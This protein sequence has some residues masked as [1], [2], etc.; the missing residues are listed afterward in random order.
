MTKD[1]AFRD[2]VMG[3]LLPVGPAR[4]R[5]MF[6]G[7][8]IFMDDVMFGLIADS[9]LYFKV[10]DGNRAPYEEAGQ[11]PFTFKGKRRQMTMSYYRVP[12]PV[13]EDIGELARWA[14]E[15]CA[16]ARRSKKDNDSGWGRKGRNKKKKESA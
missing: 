12:D 16:A 8:G 13:F 5:Q 6:G 2:L 10:D 1:E 3:R 7:T 4:A 15:A 14:D 9:A 11:G